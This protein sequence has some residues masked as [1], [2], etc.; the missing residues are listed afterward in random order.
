M[1]NAISPT[2]SDSHLIA[3]RLSKKSPTAL[4]NAEKESPSEPRGTPL[5]WQVNPAAGDGG[6]L[7]DRGRGL[8]V[9]HEA[10]DQLL[11]VL[12]VAH[13]RLH[14]E[15]VLAGDPMALDHLGRLARELGDLVD[16]ARRRPHAD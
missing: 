16:L 15:A 1:P 5:A 4:K 13:R 9:D 14:E 2:S 8:S 3:A 7:D 12:D 6:G 10:V 11:K